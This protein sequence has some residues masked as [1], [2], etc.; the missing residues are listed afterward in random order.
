MTEFIGAAVRLSPGDIEKEADQLGCDPAVVRAVCDVESAG[1]GFLADKRPKILFEAHKF[2]SLTGGRFGESNVSSSRWDRSLYGPGGAHQYDRLA[3]AME[4][5]RTA[6]L[7]SAS[8]GMFQI[9][10][11]NHKLC[12]FD[13]V[14]SMVGTM[15]LSEGTHLIAFGNFCTASGASRF[16]ASDPPD[17][18]SFAR[19]YNGPGQ[20]PVYSAKLAAAWRKHRA[21]PEADAN[22]APRTDPAAYHS[23]LQTGSHGDAVRELQQRLLG[24]GFIVGVDGDFGPATAAAVVAFQRSAGLAADGIAGPATLRALDSAKK[25]RPALAAVNP[26]A[27][28]PAPVNPAAP[29]PAPAKP[30]G[31][32][33][34]IV[35]GLL[36]SFM[37]R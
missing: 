29:A 17:F 26:A 33:S 27:P 23:T 13:D 35:S 14:E 37:R 24:L 7:Q 6:A 34:Q 16:L 15:L 31:G 9:M 25:T 22:P 12:G 2:F 20:V 11:S 3:E 8:W 1:G 30:S 28:A 32:F 10:G 19:H 36:G 4:L 18:D 5:D 21:D